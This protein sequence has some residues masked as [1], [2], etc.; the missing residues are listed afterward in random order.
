LLL[1]YAIIRNTA[2]D[3]FEVVDAATTSK[4]QKW[5]KKYD[6]LIPGHLRI[7]SFD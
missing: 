4:F 7:C 2:F 1:K 6:F 5:Q 3:N